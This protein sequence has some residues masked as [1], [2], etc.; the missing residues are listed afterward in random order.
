MEIGIGWGD[1]SGDLPAA[2]EREAEQFV[3][4]PKRLTTLL[5]VR[6]MVMV[7]QAGKKTTQAANSDWNER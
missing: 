6:K 4:Q 7:V 5:A 1:A 2:S 3:L